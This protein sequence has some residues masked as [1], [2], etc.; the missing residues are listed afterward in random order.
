MRIAITAD[1]T[2]DLSEA[3]CAEYHITL[4]PLS[5]LIDG[6][7][8]HDGVDITPADIF[9]ASDAGKKIHTAAVNEAEY[10]ALFAKMLCT[11]DAVIHVTIGSEFSAC[12]QHAC[13]AAAQFDRVFVVD[14]RNLSTGS[15]H[16]VLDAAELAA[17]G[18][19]PEAIK[20]ELCRR[21]ALVRASFVVDSVDYLRRGGRCSG[22]EA[23]GAKLLSIKPS[24]EVQDGRMGVGRKYRGS[25]RRCLE[26]Y[27][28]DQLGDGEGIDWSRVFITHSPC[29]GD[30][31][32]FVRSLLEK[33]AHF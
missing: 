17:S 29:S 18:M 4:S 27:V 10:T 33:H 20:D 19:A 14:S 23:V 6:L 16:L 13:V 9:A 21:A 25:F 32:A 3:L 31:P 7:S 30:E 15:G 26:H 28:L 12:Y 22:I 8:Y 1:S 5:V 2:C 24:I 11:H